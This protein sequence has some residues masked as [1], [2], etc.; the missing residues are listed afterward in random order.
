[1]RHARTRIRFAFPLHPRIIGDVSGKADR[2]DRTNRKEQT[3]YATYA[4]NFATR[5]DRTAPSFEAILENVADDP[6]DYDIEQAAR[7]YV[8]ALNEKLNPLNINVTIS[9]AAYIMDTSGSTPDEDDI[10][11][12]IEDIDINDI[13]LDNTISR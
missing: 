11:E 6:D 1:M 3:M 10:D 5:I 12:I 9:G 8:D 2:P 7:D 4:D 13:L